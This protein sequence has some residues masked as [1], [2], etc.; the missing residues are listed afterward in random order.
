MNPSPYLGPRP[1]FTRD[2]DSA[3]IH[4]VL[5]ASFSI[6]VQPMLPPDFRYQPICSSP[7]CDRA[8]TYKVAASWS[9][10][11]GWELKNYGL[12]CDDHR[13]SLLTRAQLHRQGLVLADGESVGEVALFEYRVETRDAERPRLP[14]HGG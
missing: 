14:E 1:R 6:P 5:V 8:A 7:G 10:G 2:A 11:S 13:I 4:G 9:D 12:A 3:R